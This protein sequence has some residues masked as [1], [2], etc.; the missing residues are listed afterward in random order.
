MSRRNLGPTK[1]PN[2]WDICKASGEQTFSTSGQ[3]ET[4]RLIQKVLV[5][6]Y[7]I[8]L[9]S[10]L[11]HLWPVF[12]LCT[13][14]VAIFLNSLINKNYFNSSFSHSLAPS[15]KVSE[16]VTLFFRLKADSQLCELFPG[17]SD[18]FDSIWFILI[19]IKLDRVVCQEDYVKIKPLS[20]NL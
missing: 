16:Q 14:Y 3:R 5:R 12:L 8:C 19:S 1:Y 6:I 4:C 7:I 20:K 11:D 9:L 2:E 15:L 17:R 10:L 18:H 13:W